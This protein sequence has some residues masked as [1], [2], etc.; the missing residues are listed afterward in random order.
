VKPH[1]VYQFLSKHK[2]K[3]PRTRRQGQRYKM[4]DMGAY[5]AALREDGFE[6]EAEILEKGDSPK[7]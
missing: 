7:G 2:D 5:V 6:I 1:V 4:V 3:I